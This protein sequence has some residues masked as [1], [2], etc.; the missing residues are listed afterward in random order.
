MSFETAESCTFS[1]RLDCHYLL[2]RP[3]HVDDA[4]LLV[5]ALHGFGSNPEVMLRL[6]QN[7]LGP[8]HVI[9]ALQA[10]S[11]F[12][13][14]QHSREVGYCWATHQHSEESVRLHHDM[15]RYVL[16]EVGRQH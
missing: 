13:L 8:R 9:A 11:Q 2:H 6:T 5:A 7:L 3:Q 16:D 1:A 14:G 4:T 15:L 12:F 10:P